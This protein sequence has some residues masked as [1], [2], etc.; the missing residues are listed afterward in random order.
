MKLLKKIK[1][2]ITHPKEYYPN[3]YIFGYHVLKTLHKILLKLKLAKDDGTL[4]KDM[5]NWTLYNLHYKGELIE[6]EKIHTISI[7]SPKDFGFINSRLTKTNT[8]IKPLHPNHHILYETILQL[9]AESVFEMGCGTG[10]HLHNL[11]ILLPNARICGIDLSSEQLEGLKKTY[12]KIANCTKR[13]DATKPWKEPPFQKCDAAFTQAVIMHIHTGEA[14]LTALENLFS[15]SEKYVI[16]VERAR[17]H[18]YKEDIERLFS[19]GRIKWEKL[20]FYYRAD[21]ESKKPIAIICSNEKLD[22]PELTDY[23]LF[24]SDTHAAK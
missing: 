19:G 5:F 6:E 20:F 11:H 12:P 16:L 1:K 14:H 18:N 13:A 8:D 7:K 4:K 15:M 23:N 24:L 3:R 21:E 9:R 22:Y 2:F 10:M 17:N